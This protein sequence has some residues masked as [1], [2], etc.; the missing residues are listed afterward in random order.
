[1]REIQIVVLSV[2]CQMKYEIPGKFKSQ[3]KEN[4]FFISI[5]P[6]CGAFLYEKWSVVYLKFKF[7]VSAKGGMDWEFELAYENYYA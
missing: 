5:S 6:M 7:K 4:S 3:T 1:M 2:D